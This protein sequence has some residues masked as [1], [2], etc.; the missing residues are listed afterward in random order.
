MLNGVPNQIPYE[1]RTGVCESLAD[2]RLATTSEVQHAYDKGFRLQ[3]RIVVY[4]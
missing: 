4:I 1:A 3:P 2:A